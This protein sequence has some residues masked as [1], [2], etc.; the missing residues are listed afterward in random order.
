MKKKIMS[1]YGEHHDAVFTIG[2]TLRDLTGH[3]VTVLIAASDGEPAAVVMV[4]GLPQRGN[5]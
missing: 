5:Q 2:F 1:V 4:V 3:G